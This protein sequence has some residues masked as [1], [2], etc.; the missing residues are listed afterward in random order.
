[1]AIVG[2]SR[3]F[4]L[5]LTAVAVG[6]VTYAVPALGDVFSD[7]EG[8][9]R[10]VAFR[11]HLDQGGAP[12]PAVPTTLRFEIYDE[13]NAG[14]RLWGPEDHV[15]TPEGGA[16]SV[17]LGETVSL[18]ESIIDGGDAYLA[19]TVG[20]AGGTLLSG[21]QRL[22]AAPYALRAATAHEA[23]TAVNFTVS[24][25]VTAVGGV[26]SSGAITAPSVAADV[27]DAT[28]TGVRFPDDSV[29]ARAATL[30]CFRQEAT[31]ATVTTGPASVDVSLPAG[32][33]MTGGGCYS[34]N[35]SVRKITRNFP[36]RNN[37]WR[38]TTEDVSFPTAGSATAY[39][40]GCRIPQ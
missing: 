26:T 35:S 13:A 32:Y 40:I 30:D 23:E 3:G 4:G 37:V 14:T 15:V 7:P 6:S 18:P 1:V 12:A 16:F 8:V 17:S 25:N 28:V 19:I 27:V 33:T 5:L 20:G 29:Q 2:K 11:G 9:P 24:G 38:C 10:L 22:L 21:R 31:S 34:S 39:I 36:V